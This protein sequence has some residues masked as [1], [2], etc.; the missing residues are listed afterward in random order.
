MRDRPVA[1]EA[2]IGRAIMTGL[3]FILGDN[4]FRHGLGP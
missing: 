1:D 3:L 4:G 2:A